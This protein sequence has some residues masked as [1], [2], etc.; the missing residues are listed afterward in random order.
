MGRVL[1]R[2]WLYLAYAAAGSILVPA[3]GLLVPATNVT[4]HA[5]AAKC[6][7]ARASHVEGRKEQNTQHEV[8]AAA[9]FYKRVIKEIVAA[10][11]SEHDGA[12]RLLRVSRVCALREERALTVMRQRM[13][14][15]AARAMATR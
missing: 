15:A 5:N 12:V 7:S 14:K 8:A 13:L 6:A 1:C 11:E 9:C 4:L 3:H 2:R 10:S